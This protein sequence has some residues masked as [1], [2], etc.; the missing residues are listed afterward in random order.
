MVKAKMRLKCSERTV[1]RSFAMRGIRF[2]PL[3]E[4]PDLSDSD[5]KE[6]MEFAEEHQG[7]SACQWE[8]FPHTVIDNKVF[9][10]YL[11]G[12]A[13]D[14]A[15]RRG[16]RG[17]YRGR[18]ANVDARYT[19]PS[20]TLKQNTG[21]HV[22]VCCAIG[23][24]KVL[25]WHEVRD[26]WNADA[27]VKMYTG[28]L[29]RSMKRAYPTN[30]RPWRVIEDNDPSGYKS[31]KAVAAKKKSRIVPLSLPRAQPRPQPFGLHRLGRDQS[32]H[33]QAGVELVGVQEGDTCSVPSSV[34]PNRHD[35]AQ[36]VHQQGLGQPPTPV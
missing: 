17:A 27:A 14:F 19:K 32:P 6:R 5:K 23:A 20:R 3:Y 34:A 12:K 13:R 30:K 4:K 33:A 2:R 29:L 10:I 35:F 16:V 26:Q 24:G 1:S 11:N 31:S 8:T 22:I 28:P 21:K 18:A 7:R 9:P 25:M 15:A 36:G